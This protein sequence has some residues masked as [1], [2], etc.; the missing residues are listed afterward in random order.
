MNKETWRGVICVDFSSV[1][2]VCVFYIF[3]V[4]L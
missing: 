3:R 1:V 4:L 2:H